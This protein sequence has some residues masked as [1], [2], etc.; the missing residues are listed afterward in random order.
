[1]IR[2]SPRR[3]EDTVAVP[4]DRR[5]LTSAQF[6]HELAGQ[7]FQRNSGAQFRVVGRLR[8]SLQLEV[9]IAVVRMRNGIGHRFA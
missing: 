3:A 2:G 5:P 7:H 1:M 8:N 9:R 6:L 4:F